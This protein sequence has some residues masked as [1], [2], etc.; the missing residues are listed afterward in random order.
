MLSSINSNPANKEKNTWK[1]MEDPTELKA[2][3][4][5]NP[6]NGGDRKYI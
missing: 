2:T 4:P 3:N 6:E 5:F 1:A